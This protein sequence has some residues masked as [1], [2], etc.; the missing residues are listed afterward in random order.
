MTLNS[1]I[2]FNNKKDILDYLETNDL[3]LK[4]SFN[5][6]EDIL[7]QSLFIL[8]NDYFSGKKISLYQKINDLKIDLNLKDKFS[9]KF[10]LKVIDHILS[11]KYGEVTTYSD[12][13]KEIGSK[14]YRAIGNVL[15]KN[16]LPLIIPCH[17]V[18][19]KTGDI[20]GFMGKTI[21]S[22]QQ[23]LKQYLIDME[24]QN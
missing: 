18:I 22:W 17:R 2:F 5:P 12:I 4:K 6:N 9:T 16:P 3:K 14:A 23:D 20:G 1:I 8:I 19:R 10:A 7:L 24:K 13:G 15:R 21:E 11:I